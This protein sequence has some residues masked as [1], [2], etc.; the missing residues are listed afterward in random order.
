MLYPPFASVTSMAKISS[1]VTSLGA[2]AAHALFRVEQLIPAY[3][4][5]I[6]YYAGAVVPLT[7]RIAH[8]VTTKTVLSWRLLP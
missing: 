5:V 6:L 7:P 3:L 8:D 2:D 4:P 1:A